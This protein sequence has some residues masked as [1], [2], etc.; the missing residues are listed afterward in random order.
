VEKLNGR[1]FDSC[2]EQ[3]QLATCLCLNVWKKRK[4]FLKGSVE[5]CIRWQHPFPMEH[6]LPI[7]A[8]DPKI[9]EVGNELNPSI[10]HHTDKTNYTQE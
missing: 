4:Y 8:L 1:A 2:H 5:P 3:C 7:Y 10:N 9:D 6:L